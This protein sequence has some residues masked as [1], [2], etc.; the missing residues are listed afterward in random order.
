MTGPERVEIL[1]RAWRVTRG[2]P[3][4]SH[5]WFDPSTEF[6]RLFRLPPPDGEDG[7]SELEVAEGGESAYLDKVSSVSVSEPGRASD[8]SNSLDNDPLPNLGEDLPF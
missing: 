2:E 4:G 7:L 8:A 3:S 6:V 5:L 1:V